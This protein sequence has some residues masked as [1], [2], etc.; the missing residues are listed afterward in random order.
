[1]KPI[2]TPIQSNRIVSINELCQLLGKG[3]ITIWRWEKNS[4]LPKAIKVNGATLGWKESVILE[5][6]DTQEAS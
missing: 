3:R 1:M 5:W 2:N 4:I 6:L